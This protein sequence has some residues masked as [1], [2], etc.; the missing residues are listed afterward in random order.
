MIAKTVMDTSL[1]FFTDL[2][3]EPERKLAYLYTLLD[4]GEVE[5]LSYDTAEKITLRVMKW[6]GNSDDLFLHWLHFIGYYVKVNYGGKWHL[7]KRV[8]TESLTT[9]YPCIIN[10]EDRLWN[11]GDFCWKTYY[12]K[13][14]LGGIGFPLFYKLHIAQVLGP[15][16]ASYYC[17]AAFEAL[18]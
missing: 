12:V 2:P 15:L 10:S 6:K 14:K 17:G 5:D 1:D 11:V 4:L 8:L 18:E 9:Y 16:K 13:G 3:R 7:R